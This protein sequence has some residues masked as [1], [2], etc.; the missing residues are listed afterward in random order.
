MGSSAVTTGGLVYVGND[1]SKFY[2]L[3]ANDLSKITSY[4]TGA[5]ASYYF[6]SSSPAI[7][8]NVDD[9]HN[10]WV[11]VTRRGPTGNGKLYAFKTVP[12]E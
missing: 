4:T 9:D 10:R 8:Y 6:I 11:F 7:G 2:A 3:S 5:D 1:T 12:E